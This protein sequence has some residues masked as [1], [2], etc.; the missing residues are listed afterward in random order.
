MVGIISNPSGTWAL[1]LLQSAG[2]TSAM[3]NAITGQTKSTGQNVFDTIRPGSAN[4]SISGILQQQK[5]TNQKNKI[6]ANIATRLDYMQKGQY[7]PNADWEKVAYYAM[8]TG[9]PV[10]T[11][12]DT[13]GKVQ[14]QPQSQSDISKFNLPQQTK[15][16]KAMDE[17]SAM[18]AKMQ[19]NTTNQGMITKLHG[20][21]SDLIGVSTGQLP[22]QTAPGT[23]WESQGVRLMQLKKPFLISLDNTGNLMVQDQATADMS[24]LLVDQQQVLRSA[25]LSIPD[26]LGPDGFA[27]QKWQTD[28]QSFASRGVPFH[29]ELDPVTKDY[30]PITDSF[31]RPVDAAGNITFNPAQYVSKNGTPAIV[32]KENTGDNI[33]P[34]FLKKTPYPNVG[35]DSKFLKDVKSFIEK[36]QAYFLDFGPTGSVVAKAATAQNLIKYNTPK[37]TN[38]SFGAGSIMSLIA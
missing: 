37:T 9:Q 35:D 18:A 29:L 3:N 36:K 23:E 26:T 30:S 25:V 2:S 28:A 17:I 7:K 4:Q 38:Q 11:Y 22:P 27:V 33:T 24:D 20:A 14:A 19:A 16:F 15:L 13:K 34:A 8:Q 6:Y 21:E 12:L 10:V 1:G 32:A 5:G 31:G